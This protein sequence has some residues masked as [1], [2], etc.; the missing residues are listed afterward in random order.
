MRYWGILL[1]IAG[2]V[3]AAIGLVLLVVPKISW[4]GHLPGDIHHQGR[5]TTF[6]FPVVTC[7]AVSIILTVTI[8]LT[9]GL[10]KE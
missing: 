9:G 6:H 1:L 3:T 7:I 4:L 2:G 8:N 5:S 10:F